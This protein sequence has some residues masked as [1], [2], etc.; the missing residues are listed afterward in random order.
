MKYWERKTKLYTLINLNSRW[1]FFWNYIVKNKPLTIS[2]TFWCCDP[3]V[4]CDLRSVIA[5]PTINLEESK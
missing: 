3:E 4:E 2:I 5:D 1:K